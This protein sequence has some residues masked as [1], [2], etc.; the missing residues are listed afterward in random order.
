MLVIGEN[1][2]EFLEAFLL[3]LAFD[4]RAFIHA[5][6]NGDALVLAGVDDF[7]D[8]GPVLNIAGVEADLVH[9]G[10]DGLKSTLK[11]EV[12]IGDDGDG[13]LLEDFLEGFGVFA[14]RHG[15]AHNIR[16]GVVQLV[17]FRDA[18]VDVI[19]EAGGHGLDGDRGVSTDENILDLDLAGFAA[20]DHGGSIWDEVSRVL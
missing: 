9:A 12:H 6:A 14:L 4:D 8:L 20:G 10:V 3:V 5:H 2:A 19:R 1:A 17:D 13:D 18:F 11:V 15:H 7:F 16:P